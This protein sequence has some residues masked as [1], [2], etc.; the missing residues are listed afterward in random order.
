[1]AVEKFQLLEVHMV[2]CSVSAS[3]SANSE[4]D[5]RSN[6]AM[7]LDW[8]DYCCNSNLQEHSVAV[9]VQDLDLMFALDNHQAVDIAV[10]DNFVV[11]AENKFLALAVGSPFGHNCSVQD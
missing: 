9:V 7:A 5:Y 3:L 4:E 8:V 1:M 2:D 10:V 6:S 11:L